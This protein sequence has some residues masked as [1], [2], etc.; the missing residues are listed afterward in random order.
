MSDDD[1]SAAVPD[2]IAGDAGPLILVTGG[3]GYIG[4]HTSVC[5]QQAGYRVLIVDDLSN[6]E[7]TVIEAIAAITG[8]R[9]LFEE[10]DIRDAS[11]LDALVTRHRPAAVIHFAGVKSVAAS[12]RDPVTYFDINVAG[13]IRLLR[14]VMESGISSTPSRDV[15]ALLSDP[16]CVDRLHAHF[17]GRIGGAHQLLVVLDEIDAGLA[18]RLDNFRR[19]LGRE[20]KRGLD[21]RGDDRTLRDPGQAARASCSAARFPSVHH[22]GSPAPRRHPS[23]GRSMTLQARLSSIWTAAISLE[24]IP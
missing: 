4:A 23:T 7:A 9:P 14:N 12:A 5:L 13:T 16:E 20:A 3:T 2:V 18:E 24:R 1:A 22:A 17:Q 11:W 10:G 8:Q 15:L 21:D 6:S 19:I